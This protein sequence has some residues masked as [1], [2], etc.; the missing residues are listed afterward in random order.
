MGA[1]AKRVTSQR[2]EL[3][4]I[5]VRVVRTDPSATECAR[6]ERVLSEIERERAASFAQDR[7]RRVYVATRAALRLLLAREIAR[8]ADAVEFAYGKR[9]KPR[10]A[11]DATIAFNVSHS[12]A[13]ALIALTRNCEV[14]IDIEAVR[15]VAEM[16]AIAKRF[17]CA[18]EYDELCSL[19]ST[20]ER[21]RAFFACWTR[22]EAFVKALG[23]GL[24][25]AL[26]RFC[27]TLKPRDRARLVHVEHDAGEALAWSVHDLA[28][29]NG[30]AAALIYRAPRRPVRV[31]AAVA[32]SDL[33][34]QVSQ[35]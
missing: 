1:A 27:V 3:T 2:G 33:L 4:P 30:F 14:G 20:A 5:D 18:R 15:P 17:F 7:E 9:G 31:S 28:T 34:R 21:E 19:E 10:L 6:L 23:E 22:K 8:P 29:E 16:E 12:G 32:A 24:S 13:L 35:Y 26:D 11:N 25:V